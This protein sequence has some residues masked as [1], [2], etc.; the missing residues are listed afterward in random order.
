MLTTLLGCATYP[1]H[2]AIRDGKTDKAIAYIDKGN[3]INEV[4]EKKYGAIHYAA[5]KGQVDVVERLL[6]A[7]VDVN[8]RGEIRD[9][10]L[11]D[12]SFYGHLS[13]I[14][15]LCE[16]GAEI[17]ARTTGKTTPI[18]IASQNGHSDT[19]LFLIDQGADIN[20]KNSGGMT[21][22]AL[23]AYKGHESVA[24]ILIENGADIDIVNKNQATPLLQAAYASH[25]EIVRML[26]ANGADTNAMGASGHTALMYAAR[27]GDLVSTKLLVEAGANINF[28]HEKTKFAPLDFAAYNNHN[29]ICEYLISVGANTNYVDNIKE[30][31]YAA[32]VKAKLLAKQCEKTNGKLAAAKYYN[33][34]G[35]FYKKASTVYMQEAEKL[36]DQIGNPFA[37]DLVV[38]V[39]TG[40]IGGVVMGTTGVNAPI[41][42][43]QADDN[44]ELTAL[45][46][47][48]ENISKYC[49]Q[50]A[51]AC[52]ILSDDCHNKDPSQ[53]EK[54][55]VMAS[56][57]ILGIT[58]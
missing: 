19:V 30:G 16:R 6:D 21:A 46:N 23:A 28:L 38:A 40:V 4:D 2:T 27:E 32:A 17:D 7:G 37:E 45:K 41:I 20:A 13:V 55:N 49:Q 47:R 29:E 56:K 53:K 58:E 15:V 24:K 26:V 48:Y 52:K 50:C 22:L 33:E 44:S 35:S 43:P 34:A 11:Y 25:T 39:L 51:I 42:P 10:P 36:D 12:A 31:L 3:Y 57:K 54:E 1:L 18:L 8:L 14:R 9:T 5:Q